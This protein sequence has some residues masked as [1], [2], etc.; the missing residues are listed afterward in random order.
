MGGG[1]GGQCQEETV[2]GEGEG[3][4]GSVVAAYQRKTSYRGVCV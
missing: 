2:A 1:G 4:S 3:L